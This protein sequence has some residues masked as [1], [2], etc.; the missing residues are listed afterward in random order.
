MARTH[1]V[2]L[3]GGVY[4][5]TSRGVR[6]QALFRDSDDRVR[7]LRLLEMVVRRH[8]WSCLAY[9]LMTTHYHVLLRTPTADLAVG[10]QRLNGHFAQAFNRKYGERGHVFEERYHS[11][12][13]ERDAH[14]IELYRYMA[15]NPVRAGLCTRPESWRWS[16]YPFAVGLAGRPEFLAIDWALAYFG[17]TPGRARKGLRAFVENAGSP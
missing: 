14:L 15:L 10:M 7:F 6:K 3:A 17:N 2:Q 11:V 12:L 4:H 9:C 5:V 1:R 8:D 16:S 13:V